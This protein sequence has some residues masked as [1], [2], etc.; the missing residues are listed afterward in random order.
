M[1]SACCVFAFVT[2]SSLGCSHAKGERTVSTTVQGLTSTDP[3]QIGQWSDGATPGGV[4]R[5]PLVPIHMV[6]LKTGKVLMWSRY[7]VGGDAPTPTDLTGSV[8][9]SDDAIDR[10]GEVY[11]WDP[12]TSTSTLASLPPGTTNVFCTGHATLPNGT[13]LLTGGHTPGQAD[14]GLPDLNAFAPSGA[15]GTWTPL[16]K[17]A[18][19]RWY[20]ANILLPTGEM[21][22]AAG[23]YGISQNCLAAVPEVIASDGT[24]A[25][26]TIR[27]LSVFSCPKTGQGSCP[28]SC[29][30]DDP[31]SPETPF[32]WYPYYPWMSVLSDGRVYNSGAQASTYFIDPSGSGSVLPGPARP[33]GLLRDYGTALMYAQDKVLVIGGGQGHV[34]GGGNDSQSHPGK[35]DL[36]VPNPSWQPTGQLAFGRKLLNGTILPDGT[37]LVTGGTTQG[38]ATIGGDASRLYEESWKG[39]QQVGDGSATAVQI[40][41]APFHNG[42]LDVYMIG[43]DYRIWHTWQTSAPTPSVPGGTWNGHWVPITGTLGSTVYSTANHIAVT[44]LPNDDAALVFINR[45]TDPNVDLTI[46]RTEIDPWGDQVLFSQ[47]GTNSNKAKRVFVSSFPSGALTGGLDVAMVG[48]GN[49]IWHTWQDSSGV[50]Q[51]RTAQA[52]TRVG[53]LLTCA[54]SNDSTCQDQVTVSMRPDDGIEVTAIDQSQNLYH[55]L[56]SVSSDGDSVVDNGFRRIGS[57]SNRATRIGTAP[58]HDGRLEVFMVG[59]DGKVWHLWQVSGSSN[60]NPAGTWNASDFATPGPVAQGV[61]ASA[62]APVRLADDHVDLFL[63][64]A[65]G[66]RVWHTNGDHDLLQPVWGGGSRGT[67]QVAA[68]FAITSSPIV[69]TPAL[70]VFDTRAS[71]ARSVILGLDSARN[72]FF[73]YQPDQAVFAAELYNP[74]T[75]AWTQMAAEQSPRTYHSGAILLPDGRVLSAGGGAGGGRDNGLE[76]PRHRNGQIFSPPYLFAGPRPTIASI[77]S[78]IHVGTNFTISSPDA[79]SIQRV[80]MLGLSSTTHSYNEGQHFSELSIVSANANSVTVAAPASAKLAPPTYYLVFALTNGVPSVGKIVQ[81]AP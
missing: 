78:V 17:M 39:S 43:I 15:S 4:I 76:I 46:L 28:N 37:V 31:A 52:F 49:E 32:S 33:S 53:T 14:S 27:P 73:N 45:S 12:A 38:G 6:L 21:M 5:L 63:T 35:V 54:S 56:L 19:P 1:K 66:S 80:T 3:A 60:A 42:L 68:T 36:S 16:P 10:L 41:V 64:D 51:P 22:V 24:V 13:V 57:L 40:A 71:G 2:I 72:L 74:A 81:V 23:E 9:L 55:D 50:W 62:A 7:P 61:A 75:N 30:A 44:R 47:V 34:T 69:V 8:A 48:L 18:W 20:P 59:L 25:G 29:D 79:S 65:S 11:V 58:F 77:P 70:P 67:Q 26:T